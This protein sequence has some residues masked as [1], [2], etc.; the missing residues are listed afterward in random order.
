MLSLPSLNFWHMEFSQNTKNTKNMVKLFIF[1]NLVDFHSFET[2]QK[3]LALNKLTLNKLMMPLILFSLKS[4]KISQQIKNCRNLLL[5]TI[6][7][8]L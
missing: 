2:N 7:L 6:L 5:F 8:I 1:A 4:A 3:R